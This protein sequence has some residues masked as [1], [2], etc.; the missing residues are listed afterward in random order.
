MFLCV[1][2]YNGI[3]LLTG[4]LH[5]LQEID[6]SLFHQRQSMLKEMDILQRREAE[7]TRQRDLSLQSARY[8]EERLK[9]LL[10]EIHQREASLNAVREDY[11]KQLNDTKTQ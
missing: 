8:E 10:E 1:M 7:L 11:V 5:L 2:D 4:N 3:S 9:T 6:S